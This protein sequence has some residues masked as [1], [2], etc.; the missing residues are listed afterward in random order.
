MLAKTLVISPADAEYAV[1]SLEPALVLCIDHME[2]ATVIC[3]NKAIA[4][5]GEKEQT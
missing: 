3:A 5:N 1:E 2:T 4:G